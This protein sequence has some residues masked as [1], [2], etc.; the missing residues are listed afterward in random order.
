[1]SKI[2]TADIKGIMLGNTEIVK[3]CLGSSIVW[4]KA[5]PEPVLPDN[6][7]EVEYIYTTGSSYIDTQFTPNQDTTIELTAKIVSLSGNFVGIFGTETPRFSLYINNVTTSTPKAR[8]DYNSSMVTGT[9]AITKNVWHV[10]K[11]DKNQFYIDGV[12]VGEANYATFAA[13]RSL[14]LFTIHNS[15]GAYGTYGKNIYIKKCK[16]WDNGSLVRNW[17]SCRKVSDNT[18]G[19]YDFVRKTFRGSYTTT[20]FSGGGD[21]T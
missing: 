8:F 5:E 6:Y 17:L 21:V 13:A 12:K 16:I 11:I 10:F 7:Q 18:Y 3:A 15:S 19:M 9:S 14:Y 4:E 20:K 1:M 2:G